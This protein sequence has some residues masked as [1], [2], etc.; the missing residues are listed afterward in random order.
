MDS[1]CRI[2]SRSD[3]FR[4]FPLYA[5]AEVS[6]EVIANMITCCTDTQVSSD[7]GLPQ[8]ICPDCL[9]TLSLA[10]SFRRL[11]RRS[12]AKFRDC[13]RDSVP[14]QL[15]ENQHQQQQHLSQAQ[16]D[17]AYEHITAVKE[18]VEFYDYECE[19]PPQ[20][21][22]WVI[23]NPR[24]IREGAMTVVHNS[25]QYYDQTDDTSCADTNVT[26]PM[27]TLGQTHTQPEL[28]EP[29]TSFQRSEKI[30][31]KQPAEPERFSKR[32]RQEMPA[33]RNAVVNTQ[34]NSSCVINNASRPVTTVFDP[35]Q[36]RCEYCKKKM[37]KSYK[38]RN[39]KCLTMKN[40]N[41][42]KA[43][44]VYCNMTFV[45]SASLPGH[46][47]N[48]CRV[49]REVCKM[50]GIDEP[51]PAA[52]PKITLTT[53]PSFETIEASVISPVENTIQN[54]TLDQ[55][56]IV[57]K[58]KAR[59]TCEY[60]DHT[61]SH[62]SNLLKHQHKCKV[63][64]EMKLQQKTKCVDIK[65]LLKT[66]E[67]TSVVHMPQPRSRSPVDESAMEEDQLEAEEETQCVYCT[68]TVNRKTRYQH[69]NGRCVLGRAATEHP[70]PYCPNAFSSRSNLLRHQRER[71]AQYQKEQP[72]KITRAT[73]QSAPVTTKPLTPVQVPKQLP[74]VQVPKQPPVSKQTLKSTD[75]HSINGQ[76]ELR[77]NF[78]K[79]CRQPVNSADK[80]KHKEKRCISNQPSDYLC[81][82]CRKGFA[83][84]ES[85]LEHQRVCTVRK[86]HKQVKCQHCGIT[87]SNRANLRKH[88]KLSC[89][90]SRQL[91]DIKQESKS[92][93]TVPKKQL[94]VKQENSKSSS[95]IRPKAESPDD[96][97]DNKEVAI[98]NKPLHPC[99]YCKRV[100]KGAGFVRRHMTIC[101]LRP[102]L[103]EFI[104]R[105]CSTRFT[106]RS[107]MY[108]HQ[109]L[110]CKQISRKKSFADESVE[111]FLTKT[112]NSVTSSTPKASRSAAKEHNRF[113]LLQD[114][115]ADSS[116]GLEEDSGD[117]SSSSKATGATGNSADETQAV[118]NNNSESEKDATE[119]PAPPSPPTV[120]PAAPSPVEQTA[121]VENAT[122]CEQEPSN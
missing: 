64:Q 33:Q 72:I 23:Q 3:D 81:G 114:S 91:E 69:H 80:L 13:F 60:C 115:T 6:Q 48:T 110:Y 38:H 116:A 105:Y 26:T 102:A 1:W 52:A 77:R 21:S 93:E 100:F 62:R 2:C 25:G 44:C 73:H 85:L 66:E 22:Q 63:L 65:E 32:I 28:G 12:D 47:R 19:A 75:N 99:T 113:A 51:D 18:E 88:Q 35:A 42:S 34:S 16:D 9:I 108:R 30:K 20:E 76:K 94:K 57:T 117:R 107:H 83:A 118:D 59:A 67:K 92:S 98:K 101:T 89:K 82:Y 106:T 71:C 96:S 11:C 50:K 112:N 90:Y 55:K 97:K 84:R 8:Q 46:L 41:P 111:N 109:R 103:N 36:Q 74:P 86:L 40:K 58:T 29:S 95:S 79:Y 49:Y 7:D 121:V 120:M 53:S 68:Q 37:K 14:S 10:Y 15:N 43:R 78:C 17:S 122:E 70:C 39:G 4:R 56:P 104:C 5:V 31:K 54:K 61:Y 24:T 27:V 119:S 87:I 45:R